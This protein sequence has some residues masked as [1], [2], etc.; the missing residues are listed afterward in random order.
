[1]GDG[2]ALEASKAGAAGA[3]AGLAQPK[4]DLKLWECAASIN[5]WLLFL[6]FGVGTGIGLMF[7]NNLGE[8]FI[9]AKF[10]SQQRLT[11][12]PGHGNLW[13]RSMPQNTLKLTIQWL[14]RR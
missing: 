4:P 11:V 14:Q 10:T 2:G 3:S 8:Q 7:V 9:T 13:T 6:V 1:M 5:F 12:A